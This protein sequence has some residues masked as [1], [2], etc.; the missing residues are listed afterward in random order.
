MIW[1]ALIV[2]ITSADIPAFLGAVNRSGIC[3][4]NIRYMDDLRVRANVSGT[5]YPDLLKLA[6]KCGAQLSV[7]RNLGLYFAVLNY[8]RRPILVIGVILWLSLLLYLP[9]RVL[10]VRSDGNHVIDSNAVIEAAEKC[11]VRFGASRR[12]VRSEKVKNLLLSEIDNLQWAGVNTYGCVAVISVK[13]RAIPQNTSYDHQV[14]SIIASRDGIIS[15]ITA[16]KGNQICK[17][18]QAVRAG[19]VLVSGYTDCGLSVRAEEADGE[20]YALTR[21]NIAAITPAIW[22]KRTDVKEN[23]TRY[24]IQIGKNIVKLHNNSGI[25]D[26]GCVKIYSKKCLVL[27]GG[28]EL[29]ISLIEETIFDYNCE[30]ITLQNDETFTWVQ[31]AVEKYLQN[32]MVAGKILNKSISAHLSNDIYHL[33]GIYSCSEMIG[34]VRIEEIGEYNGET[35]R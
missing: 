25:Y 1:S 10:F 32:D 9:T 30:T 17:V 4:D 23:K 19:Q 5:D 15:E 27:P 34:Q 13:E 2:E 33:N 8:I 12:Y 31:S 7:I 24:S 28:F 14:T 35:N 21:R 6:N 11:G 16:L 29:P 26:A 22:T 18:G 3:L 20:I